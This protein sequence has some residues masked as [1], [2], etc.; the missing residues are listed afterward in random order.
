MFGGVCVILIGDPAQLPSV[1]GESLW[2]KPKSS[3]SQDDKNGLMIYTLFSECVI[4][5]E[6]YWFWLLKAFL[7]V[8]IQMWM[9][10]LESSATFTPRATFMGLDIVR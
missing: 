3:T 2:I 6:R 8:R 4:L 7:R 1:G 5:R 10:F 9:R